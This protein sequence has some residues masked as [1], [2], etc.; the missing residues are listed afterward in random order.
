MAIGTDTGGSIRIPAALTGVTGLKP[1]R[2]SISLAGAMPLS[3]A[4]DTA[5]PLARTAS[6]C[7]LIW[8]ILTSASETASESMLRPRKRLRLRLAIPWWFFMSTDHE[9]AR[10]VRRAAM[11][12]EEAGVLVDEISG[13]TFDECFSAWQCKVLYDFSRFYKGCP[14]EVTNERLG[15]LVDRGRRISRAAHL[16]AMQG[17]GAATEKFA[18]VFRAY[19]AVI[20]PGCP[21]PAP[22]VSATESTAETDLGRCSLPASVA[23]LPALSFPVGLTTQGLLINVNY[24]CAWATTILAGRAPRGSCRQAVVVVVVVVVGLGSLAFLS[25]GRRFFFL[26]SSVRKLGTSISRMVEWWTRRSM[27][28]AVAIGFLKIRSQ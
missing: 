22:C 2:G 27:A 15:A 9:V 12:L 5:G 14:F 11:K 20:A 13:P 1:T 7:A 18:S 21:V 16:E 17:I 6:D 26:A 10:A 19:D 8:R 25:S 4:F 3:P 28:A 24:S 23:G